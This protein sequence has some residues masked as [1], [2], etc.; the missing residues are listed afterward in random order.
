MET[1][2][3]LRSG[4][5]EALQGE[6]DF[7]LDLF[8]SRL[9]LLE[10]KSRETQASADQPPPTAPRFRPTRS[11]SDTARIRSDLYVFLRDDLVYFLQ[12]IQS[13]NFD[14]PAGFPMLPDLSGDIADILRELRVYAKPGARDYSAST[15][16]ER[17]YT[18]LLQDGPLSTRA[19]LQYFAVYRSRLYALQDERPF[20]FENPASLVRHLIRRADEGDLQENAAPADPSPPD[21]ARPRGLHFEQIYRAELKL[22]EEIHMALLRHHAGQYEND[23]RRL[24]YLVAKEIVSNLSTDFITQLHSEFERYYEERLAAQ[25]RLQAQMAAEKD[26]LDRELRHAA[27]LQAR[28]IQKELPADDPRLDFALWYEPFSTVGGDYYRVIPL[29]K[30]AVGIFVADI[31]GHGISA[32]M[33]FNTVVN[34]FEKC[35]AY[36]DRPDKLLRKMNEDLYGQLRDHF[37]TAIYVRLDFRK[38]SLD[39]CNAGH[40][41]GFLAALPDAAEG[42]R[43]DHTDAANDRAHSEDGRSRRRKVR[44]LRPNGKVIGAFRKAE[45]PRQTIPLYDRCRLILYTDGISETFQAD[46]DQAGSDRNY[47]LLG[48]RGLL[49][50]FDA[51]TTGWDPA[52]TLAHVREQVGRFQGE[53]APEDDRTLLI[54]DIYSGASER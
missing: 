24:D 50:L 6:L 48:E 22:R 42:D 28:S 37:L 18:A 47:N 8:V 39:Y 44:F 30:D 27:R 43:D 31:T 45:F 7:E 29:E 23:Q 21:A 34:S 1:L 20:L 38:G 35:A 15:I 52:R 46:G 10:A 36:L 51:R 32:A 9:E 49:D 11:S 14:R 3:R 13:G 12:K 53:S 5:P 19:V 2:D 25:A 54:T 17:W 26:N 40:P 4:V 33:H 41:K 16:L